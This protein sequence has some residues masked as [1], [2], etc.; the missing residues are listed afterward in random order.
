MNANKDYR[1]VTTFPFLVDVALKKSDLEH[2]IRLKHKRAKVMYNFVHNKKEEYFQKFV[3]IYNS[4]C[5]YCGIS[6]GLSDVRLFE[7]DHFVCEKSFSKDTLGRSKAGK[8]NNLVLACYACNRG[9]RELLI[10][11]DYQKTLNPDDGSIAQ[12][13]YRDEDYYIA[14]RSKFYGDI[15]VD[16]FYN[17]LLL[18][19]EFRRL[20]YLLQ[21]MEKF[22][23]EQQISN[24]DVAGKMQQCLGLL[25]VKRNK[26]LI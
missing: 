4:R 3:N 16:K 1:T 7:I 25:I 24:P 2:E 21:E 22:I 19:S 5:A 10:D 17:R 15:F 18:H 6:I 20:D 14:I 26:T 12:V 23:S 13:F 8:V 9:K 11:K